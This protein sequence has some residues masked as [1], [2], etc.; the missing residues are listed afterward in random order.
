MATRRATTIGLL[1]AVLAGCGLRPLYGTAGVDG[2]VRDELAAVA[3]P[4]P[5]TRLGQLVRNDLLSTMRPVGQ[6]RADKYSL[7][8]V[9]S[10]SEDQAIVN[11]STDTLRKVLR[12][13]VGFTLTEFGSGKVLTGGKTFSQVSYDETGQ[14][15]ADKQARANAT[16]RAAKEAAQDIATRVAAY[17]SARQ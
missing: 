7:L 11:D 13:N 9:P 12:V 3:V 16:E 2:S 10:S 15:F 6:S 1:A 17:F 8:L 5:Q 14:S 4:E